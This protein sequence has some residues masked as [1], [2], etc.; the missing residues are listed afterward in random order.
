[1]KDRIINLLGTLGLVLA[2]SAL[3]P[4]PE[5]QAWPGGECSGGCHQ[6]NHHANQCQDAGCEDEADCTCGKNKESECDCS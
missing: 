3:M 1:M 2:I 6:H 4:A 5:A